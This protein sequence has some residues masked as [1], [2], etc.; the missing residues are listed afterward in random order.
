MTRGTVI[1]MDPPHLHL[2]ATAFAYPVLDGSVTYSEAVSALMRAAVRERHIPGGNAGLVPLGERLER[3][4][5]R[6]IAEL[7]AERHTKAVVAICV[8]V[9]PMIEKRRPRADIELAARVANMLQGWALPEKGLD[10]LLLQE[11]TAYLER[12]KRRA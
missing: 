10:A 11:V 8:T 7:M 9:W 5:N 1:Q 4:L 2:A 6:V 3:T 12:R